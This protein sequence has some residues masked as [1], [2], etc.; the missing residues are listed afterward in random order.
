MPGPDGELRDVGSVRTLICAPDGPKLR[1]DRDAVDLIGEAL[2]SGAS[3]VAI[4]VERFE[5]DFFRLRTGAAGAIVQKFVQYRRRLAIVG[6]VSQHSAAS[7]A[8]ADFVREANRGRDIWF[9]RDMT[10]LETRQVSSN[11]ED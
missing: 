1:N 3:C 6:D 2:H 10:E 9:V 8:F 5:D 11:R 4:P 7:T